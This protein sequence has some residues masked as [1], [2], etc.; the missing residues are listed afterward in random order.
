MRDLVIVGGGPA[1]LAVAIAAAKR[2]LEVLV[3]ERRV[4]PADKACGEGIL[5]GGV[6]ALTRLGVLELIAEEGRSPIEA[7]RWIEGRSLAEARLP[8]PGGLGVRRTALSAALLDRARRLG[9]DVRTGVSVVGHRRTKGAVHVT[10]D[11][12][13]APE[14]EARLL[15]AA[16]GLHS[17]IV[18]REGLRRALDR[19]VRFGIR[20]HFHRRPWSSAVEVH[21]GDG[22]EAYVT[23]SGADRVG[24]ALLCE[25]R[26]PGSFEALLA[27]VPV[28][29]ARLDGCGSASTVMGAGPFPRA[30]HRRTGDRL[31]IVGDAAGYEDAITGDGLSLAFEAAVALGDVLP[32]ALGRGARREELAP[33]ERACARRYFRYLVATRAVLGL[34]RHPTLRRRAVPFLGRHPRILDGLVGWSTR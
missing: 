28:L 10:T 2:R 17:P 16:D 25:G 4:L 26:P 23:P 1:G 24:V 20:R 31:V 21:L 3:L 9:V 6:R 11:E 8:A 34:V 22:L 13:G 27:R 14:I 15:V 33:W 29:A 30:V 7:I 19:P 18:E 12:P 5:P 32:G